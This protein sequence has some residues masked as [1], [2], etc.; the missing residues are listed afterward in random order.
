MLGA[1]AAAA[2]A[3]LGVLSAWGFSVDDALIVTRVAHHL[4]TGVGYR[5]NPDGP[6]VDCVT[7]LGY[8]QLLAP[9]ANAGA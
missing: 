8:A 6:S 1:L 4:A 3:A 5:F 9:L 2:C 7:P